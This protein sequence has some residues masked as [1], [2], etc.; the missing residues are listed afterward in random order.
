M[1]I[2]YRLRFACFASSLSLLKYTDRNI[3]EVNLRIP[4]KRKANQIPGKACACQLEYLDMNPALI[5]TP[6]T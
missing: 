4:G 1:D 2:H 5:N 6:G 3:V